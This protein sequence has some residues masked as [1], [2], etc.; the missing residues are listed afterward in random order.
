MLFLLASCQGQAQ[1]LLPTPGLHRRTIT[2]SPTAT[3]TPTGTPTPE[4]PPTPMPTIT[5]TPNPF[6]ELYIDALTQR[7][8]GGGVLQIESLIENDSAFERS[9]FV[10]RSEGLNLYGFMNIPNGEG[11]FPVV[12]ILHGYVHPAE[13]SALAYSAR[14]ADA[15]AK[16]GY[17]VLHPNLR[18]FGASENDD[19]P[20]GIG[21]TIDIL[22]L[23]GLVRSQAGVPSPLE[24]ADGERIG[25]WGHSMGGSIALR[26]LVIDQQIEAALLYAPI[27]ADEAINLEHFEFDGR[28]NPKIDIPP[29][30]LQGLSPIYYLDRI[31][32]PLSIHHGEKDVSVPI[33]WSR[34][35]CL[36]LGMLNDEVV[37]HFYPDQPHTFKNSG[38]TVFIQRMLDFFN[39]YMK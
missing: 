28:G 4:T 17:F 22:N 34:K 6:A 2:P 20:V 3:L 29:E 27:N 37:C 21:D 9:L 8:Y 18:G 23:I 33:E 35:L 10:Y 12:I 11:P 1:T 16:A 19:N 24:K 26:V 14:Y 25:L 36:D 5:S 30:V 38:D 39:R 13:Y 31:S 7:S 15:L 32:V